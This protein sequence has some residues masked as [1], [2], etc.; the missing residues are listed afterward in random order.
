MRP[1]VQY[2]NSPLQ[3][4]P[5]E[6]PGGGACS[7]AEMAV[8]AGAVMQPMAGTFTWPSW[9]QPPPPPQQ[10]QQL[11]PQQLQ[12][13]LQPHFQEVQP[14]QLQWL[15]PPPPPPPPPPQ[16]EDL[17]TK[18]GLR[19]ARDQ[20]ESVVKLIGR[21][22]LEMQGRDVH[23]ATK[24]VENPNPGGQFAFWASGGQLECE[25]S[26][27]GGRARRVI[28]LDDEG[29][30]FVTCMYGKRCTC[31]ITYCRTCT[32]EKH[33]Y[34]KV[35]KYFL[36]YRERPSWCGAKLKPYAAEQRWAQKAAVGAAAA[37]AAAEAANEAAVKPKHT[38]HL[39]EPDQPRAVLWHIKQRIE[40]SGAEAAAGNDQRPGASKQQTS[41]VR[42]G[43]EIAAGKRPRLTLGYSSSPLLPTI[44]SGQQQ[45]VEMPGLLQQYQQYQQYQQQMYYQQTYYQQYQQQ[46]QDQQRQWMLMAQ[47]IS[48]LAADVRFPW[49]TSLERI[50][51]YLIGCAPGAAAAAAAVPALFRPSIWEFRQLLAGIPVEHLTQMRCPGSGQNLAHLLLT[52]PGYLLV[53]DDRMDPPLDP[54]AGLP[55][56]EALEMI[57]ALVD[58]LTGSQPEMRPTALKKWSEML[59]VPDERYGA[60][61]VHKAARYGHRLRLLKEWVLPYVSRATLLQPTSHIYLCCHSACRFGREQ[62]AH[63]LVAAIADALTEV[64]AAPLL[65]PGLRALLLPGDVSYGMTAGGDALLGSSGLGSSGVTADATAIQD[66]LLTKAVYGLKNKFFAGLNSPEEG[67]VSPRGRT[68]RDVLDRACESVWHERAQGR[69]AAAAAAAATAA[70]TATAMAT[71]AT[72]SQLQLQLPCGPLP[73]FPAPAPK[74]KRR[75]AVLLGEVK[76][77]AAVLDGMQPRCDWWRQP[78]AAAAAAAVGR[79]LLTA[80]QQQQWQ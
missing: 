6:Y 32:M 5:Y 14:Q 40:H 3:S 57:E 27:L 17:A 2:P 29:S 68:G 8:V 78:A 21:T 49:L 73:S 48:P 44:S 9:L 20:P 12:P 60:T 79:P 39:W 10:Q 37:E 77:L 55:E 11:Q 24:F 51:K 43:G 16:S 54:D 31:Q 36:V 42:L 76:A 74:D 52:P 67:Y 41:D 34:D 69:S 19:G 45:Q 70:V 63:L 35:S 75:M 13:R 50:L 38:I 64:A 23:L 71:A 4:P 56:A 28:A 47:T 22:L 33:P 58:R 80:Q 30:T 66:L 59:S 72:P 65:Q 25:R 15:A 7:G 61:A 1:P 62:A 18:L 53:E 26:N 46:L